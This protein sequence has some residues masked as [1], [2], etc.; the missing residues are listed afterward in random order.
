[1]LPGCA[2]LKSQFECLVCL[3]NYKISPLKN[4]CFKLID[5]CQDP[6]SS[7]EC[8]KCKPGYAITPDF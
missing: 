2:K 3:E 7:E 6:L 1:M 5:G 4:E 8:A